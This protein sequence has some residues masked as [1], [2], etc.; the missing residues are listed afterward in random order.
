MVKRGDKYS[1]KKKQKKFFFSND[2]IKLIEEYGLKNDI[3][4]SFQSIVKHAAMKEIRYSILEE[5]AEKDSELAAKIKNAKNAGELIDILFDNEFP[6]LER[7]EVR[8]GLQQLEK[9]EDNIA[10]KRRKI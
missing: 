7:I 1:N 8:K 5:L 4:G 9:W 6:R 10:E 2:E 3:S